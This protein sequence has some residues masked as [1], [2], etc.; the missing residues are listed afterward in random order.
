MATTSVLRRLMFV[1]CTA[2]GWG[3]SMGL[4]AGLPPLD[5]SVLD[6]QG[7]DTYIASIH[8]AMAR[9]YAPIEAIFEDAILQTWK[10]YEASSAQ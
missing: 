2:C 9:N 8:A 4:Q 7:H 10:Q 5:F 1:T 3:H 6:G